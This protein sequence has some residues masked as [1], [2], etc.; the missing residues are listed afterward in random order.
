MCASHYP[1]TLSPRL[2]RMRLPSIL[3]LIVLT[4][5]FIFNW[6]QAQS[7]RW[8]SQLYPAD[9]TP[10][11]EDEAGRFLHDFSYAGYHKGERPIPEVDGPIYDVVDDYGADPSGQ[12]DSTTAIQAAIDAASANGGGVVYLPAGDYLSKTGVTLKKS[13]VVLRGAGP[14]ATRLL[15]ADFESQKQWHILIAGFENPMVETALAEDGSQLSKVIEV[16]DARGFE[17]GDDVDLGWVITDPFIEEHGMA[18]TWKAHNGKWMTFFRA[19]VVSID[20]EAGPNRIELDV[21]LRYQAKVRDGA[22]IRRRTNYIE[23][24]GVENLSLANPMLD[25]TV[26]DYPQS[27]YRKLIEFRDAK[28]CW[29]RNVRTFAPEAEGY[30]PKYHVYDKGIEIVRCKR[31]TIENCGIGPAQRRDAGGHGYLY[32][33]VGANDVLLKGCKGI[34]GRHNFTFGWYFGNV[35]NVLLRCLSRDGTLSDWNN[36]M[37]PSDFHH[38]LAMATLMDSCTFDDGWHALNRGSMSGGAGHTATESVFWN[39]D[40]SGE[41]RSAQYG[42]GYLIGMASSLEVITEV[43]LENPN[44]IEKRYIGTKPFDDVEGSGRGEQ[45]VPQSLYESQLALRLGG[46]AVEASALRP[47]LNEES[48][49]LDLVKTKSAVAE[50]DDGYKRLIIGGVLVVM[51]AIFGLSLAIRKRS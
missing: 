32:E 8:R 50:S 27:A 44:W 10:G 15:F 33:V 18:G 42:W 16:D 41:V 20:L 19:N 49:P 13:G 21:P 48:G 30:H 6:S 43:D 22:M 45:L 46:G 35:G 51:L 25:G 4:A 47:V 17:V 7:E 5:C 23:E 1:V 31:L 2:K 28:N 40:G 14:E 39:C 38:S 3:P 34:G 24:C 12:R 9:W 36:N 11:Y 29:V 37:G 26:D